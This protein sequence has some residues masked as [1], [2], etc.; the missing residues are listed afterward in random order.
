MQ[1]SHPPTSNQAPAPSHWPDAHASDPRTLTLTRS[2]GYHASQPAEAIAAR[3]R[4]SR[5]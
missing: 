2:V 5:P 4:S 3:S 1:D